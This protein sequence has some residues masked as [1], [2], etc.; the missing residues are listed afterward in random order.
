M[1]PARVS[2]PQVDLTRYGLDKI[3][4][5]LVLQSPGATRPPR[6]RRSTHQTRDPLSISDRSACPTRASSACG[7]ERRS[8]RAAAG[9]RR[10]TQEA[11]SCLSGE[12]RLSGVFRTH[13]RTL[14]T[15]DHLTPSA[16]VLC[17][18]KGAGGGRTK[19]VLRRACARGWSARGRPATIMCWYRSLSEPHTRTCLVIRPHLRVVVYVVLG[20]CA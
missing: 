17:C 1:E 10:P 20:F 14:A 16:Q 5:L 7:E 12:F 9:Y 3:P 19:Q 13:A 6:R 2:S 8:R 11:V 15:P 4:T 18:R